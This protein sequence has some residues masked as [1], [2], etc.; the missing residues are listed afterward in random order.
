MPGVAW[1]T[2][3]Y[4]PIS[5]RLNGKLLHG[6]QYY[7]TDYDAAVLTLTQFYV[8]QAVYE[9]YGREPFSAAGDRMTMFN[10][11]CGSSYPGKAFS[12]RMK[13]EDIFSWWMQDVEDFKVLRRKYLLYAE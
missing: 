8:M 13:V 11:V 12:A 2:I 3:H 1:R 6:V 4:K 7:Y 9:L 10:K 5:G